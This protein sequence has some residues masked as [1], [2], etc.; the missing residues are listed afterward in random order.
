M[1]PDL[2][3]SEG[4]PVDQAVRAAAGR[5][6]ALVGAAAAS[7]GRGPGAGTQALGPVVDGC[8]AEVVAG[9]VGRVG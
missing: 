8:S 7:I 6:A 4:M 9:F 2:G 3:E 5:R 1:G